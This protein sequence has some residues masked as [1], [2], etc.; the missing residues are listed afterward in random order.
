M[1]Q[2][3]GV[4]AHLGKRGIAEKRLQLSDIVDC[5]TKGLDFG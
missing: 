3:L 4:A 1:N 5:L 2:L